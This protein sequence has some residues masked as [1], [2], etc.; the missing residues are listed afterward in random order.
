M[1]CNAAAI[2]DPR[3]HTRHNS[4]NDKWLTLAHKKHQLLSY[5][6]K[7]TYAFSSCSSAGPHSVQAEA[8]GGDERQLHSV[9][10]LLEE[11]C[12]SKAFKEG[13]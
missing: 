13:T 10:G 4:N 12:A 5:I 7:P 3:A 9:L 11:I 1:A 6:A 2:A 8:A